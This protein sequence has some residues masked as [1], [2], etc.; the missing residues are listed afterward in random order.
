MAYNNDELVKE[1]L[2]EL[3]I[4]FMENKCFNMEYASACDWQNLHGFKRI[5]EWLSFK[6]MKKMRKLSRFSINYMGLMVPKAE[7]EKMDI[8]PYNFYSSDRMNING[9]TVSTFVKTEFESLIKMEKENYEYY[10]ECWY[11][12]IENK[13][14]NSSKLSKF[15]CCLMDWTACKIKKYER[16]YLK[17]KLEDFDMEL[18]NKMQ[19]KIHK[20]FE[21]MQNKV[22]KIN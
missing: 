14:I 19:H 20:K 3:N 10:N 7:M 8:I 1:M 18:I 5:H 16:M 22:A 12:L 21:K 9:N 11:K 2:K 6:Y 4:C 13:S 15:V 17:M